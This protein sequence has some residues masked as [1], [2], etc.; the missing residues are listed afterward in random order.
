[1]PEYPFTS[2]SLRVALSTD[3][4]Y[5]TRFGDVQEWPLDTV[6]RGDKQEYG[7]VVFDISDI[8]NLGY[9]IVSPSVIH[10]LVKDLHAEMRWQTIYLG[11]SI[12]VDQKSTER[13]L[14][15][16]TSYLR[17][18]RH[19]QST[20]SLLQL[21]QYRTIGPSAVERKPSSPCDTEQ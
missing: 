9:G 20:H 21:Q 4:R 15:S 5:Y 12:T 3:E 10:R 6:F 18:Y 8:E 19:F 17:R 11:E 13:R 7:A 2:T 14:L 1:M 16:A